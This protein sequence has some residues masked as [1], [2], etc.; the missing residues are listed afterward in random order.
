MAL[1][2]LHITPHARLF[3]YIRQEDIV[4]R[5]NRSSL[6]RTTAQVASPDALAAFQRFALKSLDDRSR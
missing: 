4:E 2:L 1:P 5:R 3:E 6:S